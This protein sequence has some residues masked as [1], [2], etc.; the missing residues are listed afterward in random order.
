MIN[1]MAETNSYLYCPLLEFN[2]IYFMSI[3]IKF[4]ELLKTKISHRKVYLS[5][6]MN[7]LIQ[8]KIEMIFHKI[9]LK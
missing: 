9:F 6:S 5:K 8:K 7:A 1:D 3:I 2:K 4:H